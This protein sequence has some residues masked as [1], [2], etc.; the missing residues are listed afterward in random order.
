MLVLFAMIG[1]ASSVSI[2]SAYFFDEYLIEIRPSDDATREI[3]RFTIV[4]DL[5]QTL[6]E[7]NYTIIA[8]ISNVKVFDSKGLLQFSTLQLGDASIVTFQYR[9]P[10]VRGDSA[11]ITISFES[12]EILGKSTF[13]SEGTKH[14]DRVVS[15]AFTAPAEVRNLKI[16]V[17]LPDGAWLPRSLG[18]GATITGSPVQPLDGEI[19]SNGTSL[20]IFWERSN[21]SRSDRFD[22]FVAYRF[23][24]AATRLPLWIVLVALVAGAGAGGFCIF[25]VMRGKTA[26]ATTQHT[27][28]LLEEGERRVLKLVTDAGGEMRQDD[29][30]KASGYSR[31]RVSQLV[32]HLEKL[33]LIRK[34]RFER[35]NKLFLT[36]EVREA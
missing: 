1:V 22:L 13:I 25:L 35:T 36:G 9:D 24:G 28:A 16:R 12:E 29:L 30:M 10:L 2:G 20:S 23:P 26:E 34:E 8:D 11:E 33:G 6:R 27:L 31:A 19:V 3:L 5:D 4:N 18:D 21:L 7:G 17:H 32:T 14:E 15:T